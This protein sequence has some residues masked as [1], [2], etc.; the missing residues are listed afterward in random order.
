MLTIVAR[1]R[2]R[3][4]DP[5]SAAPGV[6][7]RGRGR[8]A[9][10]WVAR[11]ATSP[12]GS[13]ASPDSVAVTSSTSS[14]TSAGSS[15]TSP[16]S[17]SSAPAI[18]IGLLALTGRSVDG[19]RESRR[20]AATRP[21]TMTPDERTLLVPDGLEGERVDAAI[22]RL[23]GLSRTKA[24]D[25]AAAGSVSL[26]HRPA[27][28]SDRVIGRRPPRGARCRASEDSP[29]LAVDRRTGARHD[30]SSTTTTTSSWSTSRSASPR[31]R[32]SGGPARPCSA[33][34]PRRGTGSR[35]PA[36]A[37]GR[38]SSAGSTSAPPG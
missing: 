29:T 28:K 12:T 11:W 6:D 24:A 3:R 25:L 21:P 13:S 8:S 14:T 38:A 19:T 9:C 26:N 4:G 36:R 5:A 15:A 17:P 22:A 7:R 18:L 37:S 10:S 33:A 31:T 2:P 1:R 32:A 30:R 20:P 35:P 27:V 34:W 16:T 23:F